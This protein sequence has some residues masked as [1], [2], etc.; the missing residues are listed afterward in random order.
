M[1]LQMVCPSHSRA[2]AYFTVYVSVLHSVTRGFYALCQ[3]SSC[4]GRFETTCCSGIQPGNGTKIIACPITDC[5][6]RVEPNLKKAI[7]VVGGLG[8]FFSFLE[9]NAC[10]HSLRQWCFE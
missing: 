6:K 10:F 2:N 8:L 4:H 5:W 9:A 3:M 7:R 1:S